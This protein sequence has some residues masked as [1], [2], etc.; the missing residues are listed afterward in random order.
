MVA[1]GRARWSS[2]PAGPD[3]RLGRPCGRDGSGAG[4]GRPA[5]PPGRT[6]RARPA[7]RAVDSRPAA[8][9]SRAGIGVRPR[10][11]P[12]ASGWRVPARRHPA[13]AVRVAP[14]RVAGPA[15]RRLA[16]VPI[17]QLRSPRRPPVGL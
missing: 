11:P 13:S 2:P 6:T 16:P 5:E 8:R 4:G 7:P 14:A 12:G 1:P 15:C 3:L 10:E 9:V 17:P